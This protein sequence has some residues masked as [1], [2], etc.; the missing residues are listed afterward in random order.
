MQKTMPDPY[1]YVSVVSGDRRSKKKKNKCRF[2]L[3]P[4]FA[5]LN[6]THRNRILSTF[7]IYNALFSSLLSTI[8]LRLPMLCLSLSL[9]EDTSSSPPPVLYDSVAATSTPLPPLLGAKL[10]SIRLLASCISAFVGLS[11]C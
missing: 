9:A 7:N 8:A 5:Q 6:A 2:P 3:F 10:P 1:M 4:C 11:F